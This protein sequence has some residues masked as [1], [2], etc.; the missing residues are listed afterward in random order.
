ML[1]DFSLALVVAVGLCGVMVLD[2]GDEFVEQLDELCG[3]L[4]GEARKNE[5]QDDAVAFHWTSSR[6]AW[7]CS[8]LICLSLASAAAESA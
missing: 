1:W 2:A 8:V 5:G 6:A 4:V 3:G 7:T